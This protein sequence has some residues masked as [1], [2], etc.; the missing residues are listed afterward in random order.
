MLQPDLLSIFIQPL[1]KS[2]IDYFITGSIAS[3]LFGEPRLTHDI[4]LVISLNIPEIPKF[5]ALF[6]EADFY[7]PPE[8]V[9]HIEL[10]RKRFAHFNL[11]HHDT[12]YKADIY[13]FTG[14]P[15]HS[16]G[17]QHRQRLDF[18][19]NLKMWVAP[20]EYVIIRKLQYFRDGG[21]DK[22]LSD[23][24]KMLQ[25]ELLEIDYETLRDFIRMYSLSAEFE[26][27]KRLAGKH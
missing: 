21:S 27:A 4:D 3:T 20:P 10:S 13:P 24:S 2:G 8:E 15:L 14:D 22:H 23:I 7:C 16:W 12:G 26:K 19:D 6:N 9:I 17:F 11:I 1:E 5:I 18:D 25:S